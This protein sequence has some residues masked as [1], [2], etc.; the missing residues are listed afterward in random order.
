MQRLTKYRING[1]QE[2]TDCDYCG[3]PLGHGDSALMGDDSAAVFCSHTCAQ[4]DDRERMNEAIDRMD[5]TRWI[6]AEEYDAQQ[7]YARNYGADTQD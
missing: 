4:E 5:D 1:I 2:T 7:D 3:C 6:S